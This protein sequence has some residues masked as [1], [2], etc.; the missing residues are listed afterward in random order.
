ME[1]VIVIKLADIGFQQLGILCHNRTVIVV[2]AAALVN[3]ITLTG[4]KYEISA[5][6]KKT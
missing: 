3:I 1:E 6:F 2:I 4:V 5:L